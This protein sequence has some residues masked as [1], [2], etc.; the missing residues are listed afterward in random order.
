M[1][2][3]KKPSLPKG[4][5]FFY[6]F[7]LKMPEADWSKHTLIEKDFHFHVSHFLLPLKVHVLAV[8]VLNSHISIQAVVPV[9]AI[10]SCTRRGCSPL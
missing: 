4:G 6:L 8:A 1:A 10:Y 2:L 9:L 5:V 3:I 7:F